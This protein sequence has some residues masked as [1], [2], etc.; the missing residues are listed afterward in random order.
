MSL[1]NAG[2]DGRKSTEWFLEPAFYAGVESTTRYRKGN[3]GSRP[4]GAGSHPGRSRQGLDG[5]G[6]AS[7]G[8]SHARVSAGRKGGNVAAQNRKRLA[9]RQQHARQM[10]M[11]REH[12]RHLQHQGYHSLLA[13]PY[14]G[15][16]ERGYSYPQYPAPTHFAP[17]P[18]P[19]PPPSAGGFGGVPAATGQQQGARQTDI[20]YN[21]FNSDDVGRDVHSKRSRT[22]GTD[23]DGNEPV[24]PP[25]STLDSQESADFGSKHREILPE[26]AASYNPLHSYQVSLDLEQQQQQQQPFPGV[27]TGVY[28]PPVGGP[29][30]PI[31][32]EED[33]NLSPVDAL[34]MNLDFGE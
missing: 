19:P 21:Y 7:G 22:L 14:G 30:P 33:I 23:N 10:E 16:E 29:Q 25:G 1:D 9:E 3:S 20:V 32:V 2:V 4:R 15:L 13:M 5:H 26:M 34:L 31:F 12:P 6:G 18:F 11:A 27:V 24:T 28:D 17:S 8:F